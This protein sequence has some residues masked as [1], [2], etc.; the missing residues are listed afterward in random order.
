MDFGTAIKTCFN[1]YATFSGRARRSEL[2]FWTLLNVIVGV[3]PFVNYLWALVVFIPSI[4]VW[5]RRLH[6]TGKSGWCYLLVLIPFIGQ[7]L[8][9]VWGCQDSQ[10]G[11]NKYGPNPKA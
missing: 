9:I 3:I 6:D 8:L 4:A 2:W 11:D 7:I 1:K 5:V 10:P